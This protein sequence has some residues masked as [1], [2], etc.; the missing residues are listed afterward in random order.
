MEGGTA[1]LGG[2]CGPTCSDFKECFQ[3]SSEELGG[4]VNAGVRTF[5]PV[6]GGGI[7]D[8]IVAVPSRLIVVKLLAVGD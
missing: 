6:R 5:P 3:R 4:F 1:C 8:G 7:E 2:M